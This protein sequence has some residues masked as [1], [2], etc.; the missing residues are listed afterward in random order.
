MRR[1]GILVAACMMVAGCSSKPSGIYVAKSDAEVAMVQLVET[2]D[3]RLTGRIETTSMSPT[4]E[5]N[6]QVI[7]LD[8]AA[9]D[10]EITVM[11]KPLAFLGAGITATGQVKGTHLALSARDLNFSGVRTNLSSYQAAVADLRKKASDRQKRVAA[12][13]AE[14]QA[15]A[16]AA[17]AVAKAADDEKA[18][19]ALDQATGI[20]GEQVGLIGKMVGGIPDYASG[21]A[22]NTDKMRALG[23]SQFATARLIHDDTI[24]RHEEF[25][26]F[27]QNFLG[28]TGQLRE[29]TSKLEAAC[30]APP[31]GEKAR[32][33]CERSSQRIANFRADY[34]GYNAKL[35]AVEQAFVDNEREQQGIGRSLRGS[36][37][38]S[39]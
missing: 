34:A 33:A 3:H 7:A 32:Q 27:V 2:P 12:L 10:D 16:E 38:L 19:Q 31:E 37:G 28:T 30:K 1:T 21:F 14:A 13:A 8:G 25:G 36:A 39:D 23:P 6:G 18:A 9:S 20:L 15:K 4:G 22:A 35:Q 29:F 5:L 17:M 24:R 11:M 26:R